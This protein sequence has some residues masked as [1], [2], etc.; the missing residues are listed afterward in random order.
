M[1]THLKN[2]SLTGFVP[3][4]I[5]LAGISLVCFAFALPQDEP[6]GPWRAP[7]SA[8]KM[9]CPLKADASNLADA[10][11]L[12]KNNCEQCHGVKGD[13]Y[14]WQSQNVAKKIAPISAPEI[15]K[16]TDGSI[17]W[18]IT[19]GNKPMPGTKKALTDDQRW[20]LVL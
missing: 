17:F 11:I 15:Q 18:K 14:G 12:Y 9:I 3:R 20:K 10:K 6:E 19:Q 5:V 8:D 13:G 4:V 2:M 7:V 16:Q 1:K